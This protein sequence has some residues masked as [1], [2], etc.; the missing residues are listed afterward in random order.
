M[1]IFIYI[2]T[3]FILLSCSKAV[4]DPTDISPEDMKAITDI[5]SFYGGMYKLKNRVQLENATRGGVT[6]PVSRFFH[7]DI[8]ENYILGTLST[9]EIALWDKTGRFISFVGDKGK[10]PG[11]YDAAEAAF[12][13]DPE[14][15]IVFDAGRRLFIEYKITGDTVEYMETYDVSF[16]LH[17]PM[18]YAKRDN[19]IYF[20]SSNNIN[21]NMVVVLDDQFKLKT[22]FRKVKIK[23]SE[24]MA[25]SI[26]VCNDRVLIPDDMK[27]NLSKKNSAALR[28]GKI[29]VFD[30]EGNLLRVHKRPYRGGVSFTPIFDKS[31][32]IYYLAEYSKNVTKFTFYDINGKMLHSFKTKYDFKNDKLK[33]Q[34]PDEKIILVEDIGNGN[35]RKVLF[36]ESGDLDMSTVLYVY[37]FDIGL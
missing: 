27:F 7:I 9:F 8:N 26:V 6:R 24:P 32:T 5:D 13:Y 36:V 11:E 18:L 1:K 12:F 28:S 35:H 10:G 15:I 20:Y 30:L 4:Y 34:S 25:M 17:Y 19:S 23:K 22:S 29:E 14:T 2:F 31:G 3:V 37:D 33:F 21:G 16:L